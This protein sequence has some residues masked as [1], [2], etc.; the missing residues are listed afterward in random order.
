MQESV[1]GFILAGGSSRRMGTNKSFLDLGGKTIVGR[2]IDVLT[3]SFPRVLIITNDPER[4]GRFGLPTM[5]DIIS[6]I[7]ALGGIHAGL[8]YLSGSAA[9]FV[10]ADMPFIRPAVIDYLVGAFYDTDA[11][12]PYLAGQYHPLL[13]VYSKKCLPT[14]EKTLAD[15]K[16]RPVEFF[17]NVRTRTVHEDELCPIDPGLISAFNV[18]TPEDYRRARLIV[19]QTEEDPRSG[20]YR[21]DEQWDSHPFSV[22]RGPL[23]PE[24]SGATTGG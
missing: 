4:Y 1:T 16:H 12:I 15:H 8:H 11:V 9:F 22:Y 17:T 7:G 6:G 2:V 3:G 13:A 21:M 18:N 20:R 14:V 19:G 5:P 24:G 10:G 23:R